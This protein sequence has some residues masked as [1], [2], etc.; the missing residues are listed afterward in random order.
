MLSSGQG[1]TMVAPDIF[2][3][4]RARDL[5]WNDKINCGGGADA[6]HVAT[7]LEA[8]CEEFW[9]VN[10][11]KGPAN[12]AARSKLDTLGL[13]VIEAIQTAV[14]PDKYTKPLLTLPA[15]EPSPPSSQSDPDE[16]E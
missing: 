6:V 14:L 12:Q 13:R 7:A 5:R 8:R 16:P 10:T 11:K 3:A 15:T 2:I 9:T 4:E 1:V